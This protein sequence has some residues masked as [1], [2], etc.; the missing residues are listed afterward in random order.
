MPIT[1]KNGSIL[2]LMEEVF[3]GSMRLG[4]ILFLDGEKKKKKV[5]QA[6]VRF[7]QCFPV[8]VHVHLKREGFISGGNAGLTVVDIASSHKYLFSFL[9]CTCGRPCLPDPLKLSGTI[10]LI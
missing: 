6:N 5:L 7:Y 4:A 1:T 10:L 8:H 2:E 3:Q 9:S